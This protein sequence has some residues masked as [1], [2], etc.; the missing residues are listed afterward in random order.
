[1]NPHGYVYE[2]ISSPVIIS[3]IWGWVLNINIIKFRLNYN[4]TLVLYK[5]YVTFKNLLIPLIIQK[6]K[7]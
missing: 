1:M 5:R 6:F 2:F 4:N 7:T 3:N